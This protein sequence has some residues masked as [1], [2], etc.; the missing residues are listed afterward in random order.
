MPENNEPRKVNL[1]D[2]IKQKLEQKK[3]QNTS[4][5]KPGQFQAGSAQ[6]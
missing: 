6:K 1:A 2:A 4:A 3:Q 5:N